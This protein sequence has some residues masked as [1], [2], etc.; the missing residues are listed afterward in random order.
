MKKEKMI[1]KALRV[2]PQ[3]INY[4]NE[5]DIP[6]AVL[7]RCALEQLCYDIDHDDAVVMTHM[8]R[9]S[10]RH[11]RDDG[12]YSYECVERYTQVMLPRMLLDKL[13]LHSLR[14]NPTMNY[15]LFRYTGR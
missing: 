2:R 14:L 15:A 13:M 6:F 7:C 12:R 1:R 8:G 9:L 11:S 3:F 10:N 4:A 5:R